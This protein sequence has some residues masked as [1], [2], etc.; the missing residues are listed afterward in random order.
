MCLEYSHNGIWS[1][2]GNRQAQLYTATRAGLTN[3]TLR[4]SGQTH[5]RSHTT[6]YEIQKDARLIYSVGSQNSGNSTREMRVGERRVA[7]VS[8]FSVF[9]LQKFI[10]LCT[11]LN[12]VLFWIYVRLQIYPQKFSYS[13]IMWKG[14]SSFPFSQKHFQTSKGMQVHLRKSNDNRKRKRKYESPTTP[15]TKENHGNHLA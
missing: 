13:E 4:E 15:P 6:H 14:M 1:S 3:A 11:L 10:E 8:W 12:C 5:K 2:S 7:A 9:H